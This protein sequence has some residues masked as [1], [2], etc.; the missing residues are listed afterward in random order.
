MSPECSLKR[1]SNLKLSHVGVYLLFE[2]SLIVKPVCYS[3]MVLVVVLL[4]LQA[5]AIGTPLTIGKRY[6]KW[7]RAFKL[8]P[9]CSYPKPFLHTWLACTIA[10]LREI[11]TTSTYSCRRALFQSNSI[12]PSSQPSGSLCNDDCHLPPFLSNF[13]SKSINRRKRERATT[14]VGSF[15]WFIFEILTKK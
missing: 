13:I 1:G 14:T 9:L 15:G 11:T 12:Q 5:D 4:L 3:S 8:W 10:Q 6:I 2:S 7:H